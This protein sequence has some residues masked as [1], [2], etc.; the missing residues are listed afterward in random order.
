MDCGLLLALFGFFRF[1]FCLST[2]LFPLRCDA[3]SFDVLLMLPTG[4][5]ADDNR[6][7]EVCCRW[8]TGEVLNFLRW[9]FAYATQRQRRLPAG[10]MKG[11]EAAGAWWRH[12]QI[13]KPTSGRVIRVGERRSLHFW[14]NRDPDLKRRLARS[15]P[16]AN[17]RTKPTNGEGTPRPLPPKSEGLGRV[18]P[19]GQNGV[20][21]ASARRPRHFPAF[22]SAPRTKW[23]TWTPKSRVR[24]P[25]KPFCIACCRLRLDVPAKFLQERRKLKG[26]PLKHTTTL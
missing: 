14:G 8:T 6:G 23:T 15:Q 16:V 11:R 22:H 26:P 7:L 25:S 21:R 10:L 4:L 24:L 17:R 18:A 9:C 13:H 5:S 1:D 3:C 12:S 2:R 19:C 20:P